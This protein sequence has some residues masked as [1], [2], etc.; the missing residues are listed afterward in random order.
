[1]VKRYLAYL[2]VLAMLL[3]SFLPFASLF[4]ALPV[5][6]TTETDNV[7][8][9]GSQTDGWYVGAPADW[10]GMNLNDDDTSNVAMNTYPNYHCYTFTASAATGTINSVTFYFR[11]MIGNN[12]NAVPYVRIGSTNYY[13][14][15]RPGWLFAPWTSYSEN[16]FNGVTNKNPSTGNAWLASEITAAQFGINYQGSGSSVRW[17]YAYIVVDYTP[18]TA[19]TIITSTTSPITCTTATLNG[20]ITD[21]GGENANMRGFVWDTSSHGV[22]PGAPPAPY[23]DNWTESGSFGVAAFAH[24]LTLLTEGQTYYARAFAHNSLGYSY[25]SEVTFTCWHD[26]TITTVAATNITVSSAR[27][28][29]YLVDGGGTACQ[30][31]FGWGSIDEGTD[32]DAY[33]GVGSPSAFAGAYT[34]GQS[35]YLDVDNLVSDNTTYFNVQAQNVCGSDNGTSMSFATGSSVGNPSNVTAIPGYDNVV[36][37]WTKGVGAP[38]TWVRFRANACP[39]DETDGALIYVATGSTYTHTGLTSGIDYCYLLVG[40]DPVLLYSDNYTIIHA[41]TLAAGSMIGTAG[42]AISNPSSMTQTPSVSATLEDNIPI[43]PFIRG[44]STSTGIPMGSVTYILLLII[45]AGLSYFIYRGTHSIE[46]IVIVWVFAS[47]AAYPTLHIPGIVPIFVSI[48]GIGYGIYRI[49]S[50]V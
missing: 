23:S 5:Y 36:L 45:L 39:A 15:A 38:N 18:P 11:V 27:L 12:G 10:N 1:M 2:F 25:G 16:T 19:P 47:W 14:T 29:S 17:T 8:G 33:N 37:S 6:A 4:F 3:G 20:E 7:T 49:R 35:P 24:D 46:A 40:Y 26:P 13:G 44:A 9:E 32:I 21:T 34:I 31:R 41:T 42:T 28:Q 48:L 22:P 43:F 50:I 30:V